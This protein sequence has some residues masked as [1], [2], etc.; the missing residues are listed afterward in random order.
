MVTTPPVDHQGV[1]AALPDG[2]QL[3]AKAFGAKQGDPP[4]SAPTGEGYAIFQVTGIAPAHAPN[5]ADW[6]SHVL[7]DYRDEALPPAA[8]PEDQAAGRQ[9]EG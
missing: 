6:K 4:Q 1:I 9:G 7:D 8:E 3:I 2:A 5:F